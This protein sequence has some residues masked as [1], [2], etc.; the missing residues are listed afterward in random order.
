MKTFNNLLLKEGTTENDW[1]E[2]RTNSYIPL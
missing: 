1:V 2:N